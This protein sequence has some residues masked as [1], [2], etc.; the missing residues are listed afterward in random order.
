ML[1]GKFRQ[2]FCLSEAEGE[3]YILSFDRLKGLS[4]ILEDA[5]QN[6]IS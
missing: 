4:V 6:G 1:L 3:E 5:M 2:E